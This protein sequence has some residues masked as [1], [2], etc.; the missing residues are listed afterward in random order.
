MGE[1][2]QVT[3]YLYTER[4]WGEREGW[5]REGGEKQIEGGG[6]GTDE[7]II[8]VCEMPGSEG[9]ENGLQHMLQKCLLKHFPHDWA[10]EKGRK[11]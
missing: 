11:R 5:Q 4:E 6:R 9:W 8:L 1:Y 3:I 10:P 7:A 2:A